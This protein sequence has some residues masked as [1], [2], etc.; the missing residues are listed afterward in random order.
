MANLHA[1]RFCACA[2]SSPFLVINNM[3]P[4]LS[5]WVHLT[6]LFRV[7]PG[8][9]LSSTL[10]FLSVWPSHLRRSLHMTFVIESM[11]SVA[12]SSL[13]VSLSLHETPRMRRTMIISIRCRCTGSQGLVVKVFASSPVGCG[14]EPRPCQA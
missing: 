3:F 10:S 7:S 1:S 4:G 14:F 8:S 12:H 13:Q 5:H 11:P 9:G 2:L 6:G